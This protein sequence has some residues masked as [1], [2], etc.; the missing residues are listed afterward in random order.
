MS[1]SEL[2]WQTSQQLATD[3]ADR[4]KIHDSLFAWLQVIPPELQLLQHNLSEV[5]Q[6]VPT[7]EDVV[8]QLQHHN[9]SGFSSFL[10]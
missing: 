5:L 9:N 7:I 2:L 4:K 8:L 6:F 1:C 10:L 3:L